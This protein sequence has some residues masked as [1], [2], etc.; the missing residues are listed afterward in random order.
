MKKIV[1]IIFIL[2]LFPLH[3]Y[4]VELG[5]TYSNAVLIY[6]ITDDK[7]LQEKNSEEKKYVAS[8]TKIATVITAID[9]IESHEEVSFD[10]TVTV[11]QK[12]LSGIQWDASMAGL[13]SG[14]IV[15]YEDLL[16]ATI[17]P[18]GA[19]ASQVIAYGLKGDIP[20]FVEE[21]NKLSTKLNLQQTHFVNTHGLDIDNHYS[22][23]KDIL[24]ILK[25]AFKN[26]KFKTVFNTKK[27][28]LTN[29][30]ETEA[31]VLLY[32][33]RY[34]F[35]VD[36]I[37]GSKTG[38]TDNA[39]RCLST[40]FISNGHEFLYVRLGAQSKLSEAYHIRDGISVIEFM[41]NNYKEQILSPKNAP[42]EKIKIHYSKT[43]EITIN[44]TLEVTKYLPN[45]YDKNLFKVEYDGP[46]ELYANS[47]P[48]NSIG[49]I[50]YYYEDKLLISEDVY[51][52]EEISFDIM[53]YIKENKDDII[54]YGTIGLISLIVLLIIK[55]ILF[56]KKK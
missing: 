26:E 27:Y 36:R 4:A 10:D 7:I 52:K 2:L 8:L 14:D 38:F 22:T 12:M 21:M 15:T 56:R 32:Q 33:Q 41:D 13:K 46:K 44:T 47:I 50:N 45:D 24:E 37:L 16:Y 9:Y 5:N 17:L 6:D 49:K 29:G 35:Q 51:V 34:N 54:K 30:L 28:T 1:L 40:Y 20:S 42:I 48:S 55:K 23:A 19:D 25:Y 39:G 53:E 3:V 31:T 43:K 11:T 18:S